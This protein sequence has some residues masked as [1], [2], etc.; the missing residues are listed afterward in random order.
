MKTRFQLSNI[1]TYCL[2]RTLVRNLWMIVAAALIFAMS[3]SLYASWFYQ[4]QYRATMTYAVT[5]RKTS[6]TSSGNQTATKEVAA[7]LAEMATT[8][9]VRE[10]IRGH[11]PELAGF[12]GTITASQVG[13]SNLVEMAVIAGDPETAFRGIMALRDLFP[14]VVGYVSNNCVMQVI[15]NPAVSAA[16][17]NALSSS[18]SSVK[19][20]VLGGAAMAVLL[21]WFSIS[22]ETVQT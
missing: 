18:A 2:A 6:Y 17:I 5:A 15:R 8:N 12:N 13:E 3:T 16:P 11:S 14:P 22:R 1:S 7:I 21:S 4:P 9:M 19:M 20:G 10:D